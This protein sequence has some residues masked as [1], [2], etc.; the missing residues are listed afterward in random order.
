MPRKTVVA[1]LD[2]IQALRAEGDFTRVFLEGNQPLFICRSLQHYEEILPAPPFIRVDR[3]LIIHAGMIERVEP[4]EG[5]HHQLFL[6][7]ISTPFRLGPAAWK[8]VLA[9]LPPA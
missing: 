5:S 3:S 8:R 9:M 2:A 7:G 6:R 1:R 4:D